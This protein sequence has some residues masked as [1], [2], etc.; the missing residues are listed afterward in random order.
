M[1]RSDNKLKNSLNR[2]RNVLLKSC[3]SNMV[4]M[5]E[6]VK[7]IDFKLKKGQSIYKKSVLKNITLDAIF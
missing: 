6:T 7:N 2:N 5:L 4:K 3:R 1:V